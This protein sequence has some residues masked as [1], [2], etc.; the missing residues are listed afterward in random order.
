MTSHEATTRLKK[1]YKIL[2]TWELVNDD[3]EDKQ[4]LVWLT[5]FFSL[6]SNQRKIYDFSNI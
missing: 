1:K 4:V 6:F 2:S 3:D 5:R